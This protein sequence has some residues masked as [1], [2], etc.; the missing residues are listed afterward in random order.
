M[1]RV[2]KLKNPKNLYSVKDVNSGA[3]AIMTKADTNKYLTSMGLPKIKPKKAKK[4]TGPA[5]PRK[6]RAKKTS[7][8]AID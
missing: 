7:I 8:L 6:S 4:T 3:K 2:R 1:L 5:K